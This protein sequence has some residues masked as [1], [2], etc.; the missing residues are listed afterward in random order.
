MK[1][2]IFSI[3]TFFFLYL[4]VKVAIHTFMIKNIAIGKKNI[5]TSLPFMLPIAIP[6]NDTSEL[7]INKAIENRYK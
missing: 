1:L 2:I 7:N 6:I 3:Y 4:Y 5:N